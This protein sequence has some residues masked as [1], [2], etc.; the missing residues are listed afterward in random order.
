[1]GQNTVLYLLLGAAAVY[2]FMQ[3]QK[4]PSGS[5][6]ANPDGGNNPAGGSVE[7]IVG[8]GLEFINNVFDAFDNHK[9]AQTQPRAV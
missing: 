2:I 1:M 5:A 7:N 8:Q 3:Q 9:V 4:G 6:T